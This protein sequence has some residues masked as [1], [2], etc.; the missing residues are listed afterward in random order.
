MAWP[1]TP[2]M[3][4]FQD[5]GFVPLLLVMLTSAICTKKV[6]RNGC[7]GTRVTL[8][9]DETKAL[10]EI[11]AHC[12][13]RC[14]IIMTGGV[15]GDVL[16]LAIER[17]KEVATIPEQKLMRDPF[18]SEDFLHQY[19]ICCDRKLS[20]E[21]AYMTHTMTETPKILEAS[22]SLCLSPFLSPH[23]LRPVTDCLTDSDHESEPVAAYRKIT[24]LRRTG[25]LVQLLS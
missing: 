18:V 12:K 19:N 10:H 14:L 22:S 9:G 2:T 23:L 8:Y 20:R 24:K 25:T 6:E 13:E 4:G 11:T 7:I 5:R 3:V 16:G 17:S 21:T 1:L 15:N